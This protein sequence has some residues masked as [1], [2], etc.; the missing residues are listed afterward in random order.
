M[1]KDGP[2]PGQVLRAHNWNVR[3]LATR[4]Y[5]AAFERQVP[6]GVPVAGRAAEALFHALCAPHVLAG[7][8]STSATDMLHD[9]DQAVAGQRTTL[10]EPSSTHPAVA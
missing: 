8:V 3:P 1:G 4:I 5:R 9:D 6:G 2:E 10:A 7:G